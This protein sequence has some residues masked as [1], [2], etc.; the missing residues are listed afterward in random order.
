MFTLPDV[1]IF[2]FRI[3]LRLLIGFRGVFREI[4]VF[5]FYRIKKRSEAYKLNISNVYIKY[6]LDLSD[7]SKNNKD[8]ETFLCKT[9]RKEILL[10]KSPVNRL[11]M[12]QTL[13]DMKC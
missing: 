13:L 2:R 7:L 10:I 8:A 3:P 6:I 4:K 9:E 11:V 12:K 5:L 1:H